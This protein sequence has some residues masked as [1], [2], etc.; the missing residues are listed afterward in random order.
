MWKIEPKE[1]R[2]TNS[3][4]KIE[5]KKEDKG[6]TEYTEP[7]ELNS[8]S[9]VESDSSEFPKNTQADRVIAE[10]YGHDR[11]PA[12]Y[13]APLD[14]GD[15]WIISQWRHHEHLHL[16]RAM[17]EMDRLKGLF[18][19]REFRIYHCKRY[20]QASLSSR[21]LAALCDAAEAALSTTDP[22]PMKD[23][24]EK[25]RVAIAEAREPKRRPK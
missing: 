10:L 5:S 2:I 25:L 14:A 8:D 4:N 3:I 16:N 6:T 23:R 7:S 1:E 19:D 15:F 21:R 12:K 17:K 18:P 9:S 20:L 24:V 13:T 22:R 11:D